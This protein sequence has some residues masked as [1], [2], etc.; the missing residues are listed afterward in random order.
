[1]IYRT[2]NCGHASYSPT[3]QSLDAL[4]AALAPMSSIVT[5]LTKIFDKWPAF[6]LILGFAMS[7]AWLA[8]LVWLGLRLF[9]LL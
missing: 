6:I 9:H 1:M 5:A 4:S 2:A 3:Q 7:L 8:V